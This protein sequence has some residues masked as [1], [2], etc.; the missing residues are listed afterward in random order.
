MEKDL[1]S[2]LSDI[3]EGKYS[4]T[5][6]LAFLSHKGEVKDN[7]DQSKDTRRTARLRGKPINLRLRCSWEA[8]AQMSRKRTIVS[9]GFW[10]W[11][12]SF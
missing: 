9:M 7:G 3:G 4:T 8:P 2:N 12:N 5:A 10:G 11:E 6:L 1:T